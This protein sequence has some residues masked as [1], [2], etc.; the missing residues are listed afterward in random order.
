M[1]I[2]LN[3][4]AVD[5]HISGVE[6]YALRLLKSLLSVGARHSYVVYTN[7]PELVRGHVPASNNLTI[8]EVK[9]LGTRT[10]RI[11]WEHTQ[12]PRLAA[13]QAIDVLHC[14]SYICPVRKS[15]MPYVVTVHDTIAI[16][17]PAWCKPTNA[18]Y[19]NLFMKGA[20]QR[21]SRV[22]S[23]SKSTANDMK[24]NFGLSDSKVRVV[25]PGIDEIFKAQED[26][27]RRDEIRKRYNLPPRYVLFVGNIE[28]KKNVGALLSLESRLREKGLGHKLVMVGKR[29]WCSRSQLDQIDKAV[30]ASNII[31]TGYVAVSDLPFVYAMADV[32]VFPSFYEGFGFPPLEAMACGTPVVSSSRG[33]LAESVADAAVVVE[34]DDT[35]QI[36]EAV[37][38]MISDPALRQEYVQKGLAQSR[39]FKWDNSAR[40]TLSLYEEV[41]TA[42]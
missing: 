25:Y 17:H 38:S 23:V 3:F 7:Q 11:L 15:S 37:L 21:A 29:S 18:L 27:S 26:P 24:R 32:F 33:A 39:R 14:P 40:Q 42:K 19:F 13:K 30:A 2:G 4:H 12:L 31:V 22:I 16:D 10:A 28:P 35:E 36:V 6:Y 34:P 1:K 5:G 9:H 20:I 8:V 41:C